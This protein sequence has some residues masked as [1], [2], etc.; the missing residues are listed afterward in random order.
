MHRANQD[1]A[2]EGIVSG[3]LGDLRRTQGR[4]EEAARWYTAGL[5]ASREVGNRRFEAV[6]VA[7]LGDLARDL[8]QREEARGHY[9][10]AV[11][12]ARD[13]GHRLLEGY[14]WVQLAGLV[15]GAGALRWLERAMELV[16]SVGARGRQAEALAVRAEIRWELGDESGAPRLAAGGGGAGGDGR[17]GGGSRGARQGPALGRVSR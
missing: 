17:R 1:R 2:F 14:A 10:R 12:L 7:S 6:G 3:N 15:R 16:R 11:A 4:M 9:E 5:V 8:G 13:V